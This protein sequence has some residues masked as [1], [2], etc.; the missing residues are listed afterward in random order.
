MQRALRSILSRGMNPSLG[1]AK[2]WRWP[3]HGYTGLHQSKVTGHNA[4]MRGGLV[5]MVGRESACFAGFYNLD[6]D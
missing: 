3:L 2:Y 5:G 1:A 6:T 4:Y